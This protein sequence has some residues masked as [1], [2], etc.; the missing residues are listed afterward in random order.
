MKWFDQLCSRELLACID[1]LLESTLHRCSCGFLGLHAKIMSHANSCRRLSLRGGGRKAKA[2]A[3][4]KMADRG[5]LTAKCKSSATDTS[6]IEC[7][8]EDDVSH[9]NEGPQPALISQNGVYF[10]DSLRGYIRGEYQ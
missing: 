6:R 7:T 10:L 5:G 1:S 9:E 4:K 8:L 2:K 3:K